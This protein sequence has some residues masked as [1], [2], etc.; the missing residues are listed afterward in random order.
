MI[1]PKLQLPIAAAVI[2]LAHLL[3]ILGAAITDNKAATATPLKATTSTIAPEVI[4]C[5]GTWMSNKKG[6]M[7]RTAR[8]VTG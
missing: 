3:V 6:A 2:G 1:E 8:M 5:A 7:N 4:F